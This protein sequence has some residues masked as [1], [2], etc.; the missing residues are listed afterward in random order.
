M[1]RTILTLEIEPEFKKFL[2]KE[3]KNKDVSVSRLA[4]AALKKATKY[5]EPE[6]V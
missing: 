3:A 5:K 4:R 6:L 1:K 2:E